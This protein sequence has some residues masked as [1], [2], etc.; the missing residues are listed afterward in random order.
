MIRNTAKLAP[1]P[2]APVA[3]KPPSAPRRLPGFLAAAPKP[4]ARPAPTPAVDASQI[5]SGGSRRLVGFL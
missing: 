2:K 4:A 1:A 5:S 3:S